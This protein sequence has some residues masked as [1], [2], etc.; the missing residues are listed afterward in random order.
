MP[1]ESKTTVVD[2]DHSAINVSANYR[3]NSLRHNN[4]M[5]WKFVSFGK[6][7]CK[8]VIMQKQVMG[9]WSGW[10]RDTLHSIIRHWTIN[11]ILK[12]LFEGQKFE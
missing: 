3:Q 5:L 9:G 6:H 4:V 2:T 7:V 10:D 12:L 8:A 11:T 1:P